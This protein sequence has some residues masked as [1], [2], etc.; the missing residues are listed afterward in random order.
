VIRTKYF[1][2]FIKKNISNNIAAFDREDKRISIVEQKLNEFTKLLDE[3][4]V[5][6]RR[7]K[8]FEEKISAAFRETRLKRE[9]LAAFEMLDNQPELTR[10]DL[11]NNLDVLLSKHQLN[12]NF[13]KKP[14]KKDVTKRIV[15][16]LTGIVLITLGFSMIILPAPPYFEM[17]TIF[18]FN[19]NDGITI[20]DLI[21]LLI[22]LAGVYFIV[23]NISK[24]TYN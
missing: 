21:S 24:E 9:K 10:I 3:T 4:N 15:L 22:I 12:S 8:D 7:L 19:D 2:L 13:T 1:K 16:I 18:Y 6:S 11:L 20:M 5:D 14:L 23:I 17:F